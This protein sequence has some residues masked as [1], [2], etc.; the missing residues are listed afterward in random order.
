MK[1]FAG[2]ALDNAS[3]VLEKF[4]S[5]MKRQFP[6]FVVGCMLHVL[7]LVLMNSY[8]RTFGK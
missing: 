1:E 2:S 4:V 3:D 8:H 7:N 6:G 5:E